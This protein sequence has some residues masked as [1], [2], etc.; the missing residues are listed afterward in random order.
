MGEGVDDAGG[1]Y[2]ESIS[3]MCEELVNGK[4][5]TLLIGT[6]N[7]RAERG[8]N[9]DTFLLHP[10]ATDDRSQELL[11]FLGVLMGIAVRTSSPIS[12]PMAPL[13]W[14]QLTGLPITVADLA[15][16]DVDYVQCVP[17]ACTLA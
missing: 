12:L 14:R 5:S 8:D 3:E 9:R 13:F 17:L 16:V 6:P 7:G 4:T 11:E 15:E 1:G 10:R 2:S